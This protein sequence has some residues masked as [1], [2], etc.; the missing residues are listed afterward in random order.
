MESTRPPTYEI[1]RVGRSGSKFTVL[2]LRAVNGGEAVNALDLAAYSVLM[3]VQ[4]PWWKVTL[5]K[6]SRMFLADD[7][8]APL[9]SEGMI[10][11][12]LSETLIPW[13]PAE[14]AAQAE[15]YE[16]RRKARLKK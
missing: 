4:T 1:F 3:P 11:P 8:A 7:A 16:S 12:I 14:E 15:K 2:Q 5:G 6:G 10:E 13:R 9:L